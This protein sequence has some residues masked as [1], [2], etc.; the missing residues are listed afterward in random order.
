MGT[1]LI[2][3][4][5][6]EA[7]LAE[8]GDLVAV[9]SATP[10]RARTFA[11]RF[12]GTAAC[13]PHAAVLDHRPDV[14]YV[15]TTND[16]H[17]LDALA[18]IEAGVPVLVEKPF[19]LTANLA[20]AVLRAAE[21]RSVLVAEAMWMRLQPGYLRA[22]RELAAGTIGAPRLVDASFGVVLDDDPTRRWLSPTLGGGAILDLGVYPAT[23]AHDVL[24]PATRIQATGALAQTGVD[25]R[26]V[27]VSD[28][29][30]GTAVW[31]CSLAEPTGVRAS[32]TG[33]GGR[34]DL[35]PPFHHAPAITITGTD[36]TATRVEVEG[37][38]LG[39]RHEVREMERCLTSGV[40]ES[41]HLRH[42]D[43]VAVLEVLDQVAS[44]LG[45]LRPEPRRS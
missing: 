31:T 10:E 9:S 26:A 6:A 5:F 35:H 41:P 8:Q 4:S 17:H 30:R 19:A 24:G 42:D 12:P 23:L 27:V 44:R 21:Q 43:T 1:G 16:R 18:C 25:R 7:I 11:A 3:A 15:A 2:A 14:V 37:A 45:V 34:I 20:R 40:L 32:I 29:P 22:R 38:E 39:Y 28:H 33:P 36:G 13:S